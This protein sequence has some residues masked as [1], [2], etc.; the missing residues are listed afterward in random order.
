MWWGL[1]LFQ[2]LLN[3]RISLLFNR[4]LHMFW[5]NRLPRL[6]K[7]VVVWWDKIVV[8]S[9]CCGWS[10]R[11]PL[12]FIYLHSSHHASPRVLFLQL[13]SS[14]SIIPTTLTCDRLSY[15]ITVLFPTSLFLL[16]IR[17]LI[18]FEG[19][20]RLPIIA[21]FWAGVWTHLLAGKSNSL[22]GPPSRRVPALKKTGGWMGT[23]NLK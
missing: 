9:D 7:I 3:S 13:S 8:V 16:P 6:D 4:I 14:P 15:Y 21:Q 12:L 20:Q 17:P 5:W 10:P 22:L 23:Y 1:V 19:R 18:F 2:Q 11:S